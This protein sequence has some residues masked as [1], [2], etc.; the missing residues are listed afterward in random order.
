MKIL[1]INDDGINSPGIW[2]AAR[3]LRQVGEVVVVAPDRQQSGVGACLTLHAPVKAGEWRVD[4]EFQG[5][6][7][8]L[9]PVSAFSVEG[10]PGD[11][12]ILALESLVQTVDLVVSGVNAG[13]NVGYDVMV[14][15]TV[16]GA[17]QSYVRGI[18][19]I[20]ISVAAVTNTKYDIAEK[21][22]KPLAEKFVEYSG[23]TLFLNVN[24]PKID[25]NQV[26]GVKVT[27]LGGRSW[28]E[29]VKAEN[30]GPEK[31]YWISR[32]KPSTVTPAEDSDI[33]A[34][35][36]NWISITPLHLA[37]G[38]DEAMTGVETLIGD[39]PQQILDR[40]D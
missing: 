7:D 30:V 24:I 20:A 40:P 12:C 23:D 31:R 5:E 16:G 2:A 27:R 10:T 28:G 35:K 11:S 14:S 21:V 4:Q 19:T 29:N 38:N 33:A 39:I 8:G 17:V 13:S 25:M 34:I 1:V 32:N 6:S 37:L 22:L 15:G 26:A 18:N 9:F 3:A 36:K